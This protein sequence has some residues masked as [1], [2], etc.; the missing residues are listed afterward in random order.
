MAYIQLCV[1]R[2]RCIFR[3]FN[4]KKR[5]RDRTIECVDRTKDMEKRLPITRDLFESCDEI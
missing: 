5:K 1:L 3:Y 4:C 2:L